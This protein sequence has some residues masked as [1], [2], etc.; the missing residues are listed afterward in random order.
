MSPARS[1]A[2]ASASPLPLDSPRAGGEAAVVGR[3]LE[4]Q[5]LGLAMVLAAIV[6]GFYLEQSSFPLNDGGL[7]FA[8]IRD[9]QH[10]HYAL[11][12][13][14]SYDPRIP[15]AYPPLGLYCVALL[16]DATHV[17]SIQWMRLVPLV[18]TLAS[19][20]VFF[21][22]SRRLLKS[23]YAVS[24]S[25]LAFVLIPDNFSWKVMGGGVTRSFGFLFALAALCCLEQMYERR[26][27]RLCLA[28]GVF[29]GLTVLAHPEA[30]LFLAISGL[31]LMA[32][33]G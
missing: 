33:W 14:T 28:S 7:F 9:I 23:S 8:M 15:F 16:A 25:L 10:A 30:S 20:P 29:A 21:L 26:S 31:L 11:P 6:Y 19:T 13:V 18:V 17:S 5:A 22:L 4:Y 27:K 2:T 24:A 3:R 32:W 12:R 1:H